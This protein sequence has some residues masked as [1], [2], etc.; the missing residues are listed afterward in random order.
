MRDYAQ[1]TIPRVLERD[2]TMSP[3]RK[4]WVLRDAF[5]RLRRPFSRKIQIWATGLGPKIV[6]RN[7]RTPKAC[8]AGQGIRGRSLRVRKMRHQDDSGRAFK[9]PRSEVHLRLQGLQEGST[10]GREADQSGLSGKDFGV[11]I[12][13]PP[14]VADFFIYAV[15]SAGL[16]SYASHAE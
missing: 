1:R 2:L 5:H 8:R 12:S 11:C 16:T 13:S 4:S 9:A 3:N 7:T 15:R 14:P 10:C 6:R